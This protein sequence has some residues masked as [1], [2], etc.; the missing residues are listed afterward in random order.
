VRYWDASALVP[1]VLVED[2]TPHL[3]HLADQATIITWWLSDVEIASAIE[4]RSREGRLDSH[5]RAQA[6]STL[7]TLA[8]S[9]TEVTAVSAVRERAYRLL[10]THALRAADAVQLAAALVATG[11]RPRDHEF[12]ALDVR[13]REAAQREGFTVPDPR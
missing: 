4:R 3:E 7:A 8:I 2:T 10:A 6:L 1:L 5:G 11:D 13:L 9:W 12:I